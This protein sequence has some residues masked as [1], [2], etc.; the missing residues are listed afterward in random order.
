MNLI[1]GET[2]DKEKIWV[3][4]DLAKMDQVHGRLVRG[5][6]DLS[7]MPSSNPPPGQYPFHFTIIYY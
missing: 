4:A 6:S 5:R 1:D 3:Y 2:F 7:R